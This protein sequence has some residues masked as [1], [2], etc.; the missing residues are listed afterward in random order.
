MKGPWEQIVHPDV[1]R[2]ITP[3]DKPQFPHALRIDVGA[4]ISAPLCK[5]LVDDAHDA[6][7]LE[8]QGLLP[9]GGI[10][11]MEETVRLELG[12]IPEDAIS[13]T[14]WMRGLQERRAPLGSAAAA[15]VVA[16]VAD[17]LQRIS[18]SKNVSA[19]AHAQLNQKAVLISPSRGIILVGGQRPALNA[20]LLGPQTTTRHAPPEELRDEP[21]DCRSDVFRLGVLY[22]EL[23]AGFAYRGALSLPAARQAGL[24]LKSPELP[25]MLPNP[26]HGLIALLG[27]AL[28]PRPEHRYESTQAFAD[29]VTTEA[30][31][32]GVGIADP[33]RMSKLIQE[34]VPENARC[35]PSALLDLSA[36][37]SPP[38]HPATQDD[39]PRPQQT[40]AA[41]ASF[42]RGPLSNA[43]MHAEGRRGPGVPLM[44]ALVLAIALGGFFWHRSS[45]STARPDEKTT[46][47]AKRR[48]QPKRPVAKRKETKQTIH[49][50]WLTV[51]SK[52]SGAVVEVDGG[53]VGT[54]PLVLPHA[55]SN[56]YYK[57]SVLREGYRPFLKSARPDPIKKTISINAVLQKE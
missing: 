56:K 29:A 53:Y 57:V 35:G 36:P 37:Y 44:A 40:S 51:V 25:D 47:V 15:S 27:R 30:I 21:L 55:F 34:F 49:S 10:T 5:R 26:R 41:E 33:E 7:Q 18:A 11:L 22:Y 52:P 24:N 42:G 54:T 38:A 2:S 19:S 23:L 31:G 4:P 45:E 48:V 1:E 20:A 32:S 39:L 17:I 3:N 50:G 14:A 12:P 6:S 9:T 43:G 28:A 46:Q 13:L 16:A 8:I